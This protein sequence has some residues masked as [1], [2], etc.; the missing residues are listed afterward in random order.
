MDQYMNDPALMDYFA[1]MGGINQ[2]VSD[3]DRQQLLAQGLRQRSA[4]PQARQAGQAYVAAHPL[5]HLSSALGQGLAS[6]QEGMANKGM[7]GMGGRRADA[8][9]RLRS[10]MGGAPGAAPSF[11][12]Y[13]GMD[14]QDYGGGI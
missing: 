12:S 7:A 9:S 2:D 8:L 4:T 6:Y 5:E 13:R 11:G 10:T 14:T 3:L 1:T